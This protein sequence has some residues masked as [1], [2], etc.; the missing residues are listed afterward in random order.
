MAVV[1]SGLTQFVSHARI[2][3]SRVQGLWVA[4]LFFRLLEGVA[5][6]TILSWFY[7]G[8]GDSTWPLH[9]TFIVYAVGNLIL[10]FVHRRRGLDAAWGWFD[11][12][13]NVLPM[14]VAAHWSG[15]IYSPF[16]PLFVL[17]IAV[18]T[19]V[20]GV[21]TGWQSV[22]ATALA[23]LLWFAIGDD[24]T[25]EPGPWYR[26]L[27][28]AFAMLAY[29]IIIGGALKFFPILEDRERRLAVTA[30]EKDELY[31][32]SM[33]QQMQLRRLSQ[34]MM[35]VSERTMRRIAHELHDDLGQ[36]LTAVKMDLGLIE[37]EIDDA[38]GL[39]G[40]VRDARDQI[41]GVLH[42]VRNLSHLLRPAA[43]D[44][45]G[46]VPAMESFV[47]S[48]GK[49][50]AVSV[51]IDAPPPQTRLPRSME[52]AL[53]RVLQEGLTNVARHARAR[54]VQVSLRVE[55]V[56]T[57]QIQD[58]GCGF[59]AAEFLRSPPQGH[60]M[61]VFGMRERVASYGGQFVIESGEGT[62]TQVRLSIPL[63][64]DADE[65]EEDDGEDPRLAH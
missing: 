31:Q 49:R 41:G 36:A 14:T 56:V 7:F 48:F 64:G 55:D 46:L 50:N 19:V 20:Y 2:Q 51:E 57:L 53:Y 54:H 43:L 61:G 9:L 18:Y 52:L 38:D 6:W 39:R 60:G 21:D 42:E 35:R 24:A 33:R 25:V 45:L 59:D 37:R 12:G 40:R 5:C 30:R 17:K 26:E 1:W 34:S 47:N 62:G 58:D 8:A 4:L 3:H 13:V 22:V 15:G 27:T 28:L 16:V 10:S 44:D 32:Q 63:G 29:G 23:G 65:S 11:V